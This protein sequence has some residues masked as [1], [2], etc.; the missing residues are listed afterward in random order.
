LTSLKTSS[1]WNLYTSDPENRRARFA[2]HVQTKTCPDAEAAKSAATAQDCADKCSHK[3]HFA[4]SN[5][6]CQCCNSTKGQVSKNGTNIYKIESSATTEKGQ[7]T[8]QGGN[9]LQPLRQAKMSSQKSS[10]KETADAAI[11]GNTSSLIRSKSGGNEYFEAEF[12][13]GETEVTKVVISAGA[14]GSLANDLLITVD[15]TVCGSTPA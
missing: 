11:D 4:Y 7:C 8:R 12:T 13:H 6:Q 3:A 10:N 5:G 15:G 2:I 1:V 14:S 9:E